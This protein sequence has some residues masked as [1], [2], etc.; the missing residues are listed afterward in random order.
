MSHNPFTLRLVPV[1]PWGSG[2]PGWTRRWF[3]RLV[4]GWWV[5]HPS[6]GAWFWTRRL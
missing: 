3:W 2:R 1:L 4:G 6:K 5:S